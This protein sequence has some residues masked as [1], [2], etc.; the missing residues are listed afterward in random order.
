MLSDWTPPSFPLKGGTI[1]ARGIGAGPQ[2]AR[3]MQSVEKRWV[4]E[5]FPNPARVEQL[6][7]E[8]LNQS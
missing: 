7:A 2:V 1:V 8:E 4:E 6:L 5:G 3:I